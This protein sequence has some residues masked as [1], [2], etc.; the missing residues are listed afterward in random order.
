MTKKQRA[1]F[2]CGALASLAACKDTTGPAPPAA[3]QPLSPPTLSAMVGSEVNLQV[4]VS[5]AKGK[6]RQRVSVQWSVAA[7]SINPATAQTD[8]Q[9]IATTTWVLGTTAGEQTATAT[10][11]NLPP[12]IFRAAATPGDVATLMIAPAA[13]TLDPGQLKQLSLTAA[14]QYGNA[15]ANPPVSFSSSDTT[16]AAVAAS[17]RVR[18]DWPGTALI[19]AISGTQK[20]TAQIIVRA[21]GARIGTGGTSSCGLARNGEAFCWGLNV[22]GELGIGS[23]D[24]QP[25][26]VPTRVTGGQRFAFMSVGSSHS[27][28]LT[29]SGEA[30]C[31]GRNEYGQLG[32]TTTEMCGPS[33]NRFPCSSTPVRVSGDLTF[34]SIHAGPSSACGITTTHQAY[35]WGLNSEGQLGSGTSISHTPTPIPIAGGHNFALVDLGGSHGCGITTSGETYCWGANKSGQLGNPSAPSPSGPVLVTGGHRFRIIS[36]NALYTCG[37]TIEG[38]AYCWGTNAH[39]QLGNGTTKMTSTPTAVAGGHMFVAIETGSTHACAITPGS[40]AYCWGDNQR[41][42]L[43]NGAAISKSVPVP[44]SGG[45]TF[46]SISAGGGHTCGITRAMQAYCWGLNSWGELGTGTTATSA[47]PVRVSGFDP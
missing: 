2:A 35:C 23:T 13:D 42:Q 29:S 22:S 39:G 10:V 6:P 3:V 43:G 17:G 24:V 28:G 36:A 38:Q 30:F 12:V 16:V 27:C 33:T 21:F 11:A 32:T 7:G 31:W 25:H 34:R 26:P 4:K 47:V 8:A 44:V 1:L 14:D 19:S 37:L 45:L 9:G 40:T 41:G 15:I 5:D 46:A 20:A 18:A